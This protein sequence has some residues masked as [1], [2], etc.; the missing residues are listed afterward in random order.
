MNPRRAYCSALLITSAEEQHLLDAVLEAPAD[1]GPRLVL[2]DALQARGEPFGEYIAL[3]V[4]VG[5]AH[6][7]WET[8]AWNSAGGARGLR[9]TPLPRLLDEVLAGHRNA[10]GVSLEVIAQRRR[11]LELET[12]RT[13]W[14][15]ELVPGAKTVV[16]SRGFPSEAMMA[17]QTVMTHSSPA[18]SPLHS[19]Q[20]F[21]ADTIDPVELIAHP[22]SQRVRSLTIE[23]MT[24][25]PLTT[26]RITPPRTLAMVQLALPFIDADTL[27][28]LGPALG[29]VEQFELPASKWSDLDFDA[30]IHHAPALKEL[31][32]H[33]LTAQMPISTRWR[34][35]LAKPGLTVHFES[36]RVTAERF[37]TFL[38]DHPTWASLGA[39]LLSRQPSVN[40]PSGASTWRRFRFW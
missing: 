2:A 11:L 20:L 10:S 9:E 18:R 33:G 40:A 24:F 38:A 7:N 15:D 22:W 14:V 31:T 23:A 13:Q 27:T 25:T 32:V 17:A 36:T 12:A 19:L 3:E 30:V 28:R 1:D 37:E 26:T 4:K 21:D 29:Q 34:E 39:F 5:Q 16:W 8:W 6:V 35:V